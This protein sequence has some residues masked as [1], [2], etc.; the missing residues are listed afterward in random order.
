MLINQVNCS[1]GCVSGLLR[2]AVNP[3]SE[4]YACAFF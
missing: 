1:K 3:N 2:P 4:T